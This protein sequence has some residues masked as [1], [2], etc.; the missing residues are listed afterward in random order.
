MSINYEITVNIFEMI[1]E[2]I[3]VL[4]LNFKFDNLLLK[5]EILFIDKINEIRK[6]SKS[7]LIKKLTNESKNYLH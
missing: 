2:L 7:N 3:F 4:L 6:L 5:P 1:D